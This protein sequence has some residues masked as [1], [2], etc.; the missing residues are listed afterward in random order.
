MVA[1]RASTRIYEACFIL[2]LCRRLWP[3]L[4]TAC[5]EFMSISICKSDVLEQTGITDPEFVWYIYGRLVHHY[6]NVPRYRAC[7]E[8]WTNLEPS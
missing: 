2:K 1:R 4:L 7:A 3:K 5:Q 6:E 8:D